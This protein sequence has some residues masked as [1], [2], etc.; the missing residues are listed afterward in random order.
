MK[1]SPEFW[2]VRYLSD[3]TDLAGVTVETTLAGEAE[4]LKEF[5]IGRE[6]YNRESS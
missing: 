5:L 2:V 4:T 1:S 6:V 3:R